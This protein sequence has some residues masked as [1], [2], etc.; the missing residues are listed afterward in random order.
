MLVVD[1]SA[2][3][4]ACYAKD[5]FKQFKRQKLVAPPL[6]WSEA[7][8]VIRLAVHKRSISEADGEFAFEALENCAIEC[9]D[10][11]GL[12]RRAWEI[13][14]ELGWARTYDAE[15][16]GLAQL[17]ECRLVTIDD[18]LIRGTQRLGIAVHPAD[19]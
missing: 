14:K 8:S 7:R 12:G 16:V 6:M 10:H 4:A 9:I 1:A 11:A 2:T 17:L 19:L 13:A 5:G 18:R 15:F 3:V